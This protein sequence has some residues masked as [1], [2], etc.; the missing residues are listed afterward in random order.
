[1]HKLPTKN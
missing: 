1:M